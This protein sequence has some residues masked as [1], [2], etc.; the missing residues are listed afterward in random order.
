MSKII[1]YSDDDLDRFYERTLRELHC[2]HHGLITTLPGGKSESQYYWDAMAED[3]A[4]GVNIPPGV[5]LG[6]LVV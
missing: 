3:R 4:R 6:K 2:R 5:D 1:I